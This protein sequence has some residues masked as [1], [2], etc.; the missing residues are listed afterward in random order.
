MLEQQIDLIDIDPGIPPQAAVAGDSVEKAVQDHQHAHGEQLFAQLP[1]IIAGDAGAHV[2][3]GGL[4]KSV[5]TALREQFQSQSH[6]PRLGFRLAQQFGV[7]VLERGGLAPAA[8]PHIV[9]VALCCT[10]VDDRLLLGRQFSGPHRLLTERKQELR[11]QHH[12]VFPLAI[13]LLHVHGVDVVAGGG[14]DLHHLAT[15]SF[16][17]RTVFRLRIDDQDVILGRESQGG[18]LPLGSKGFTGAR[19]AQNKS[20][21]VEVLLAVGNDE[22]FADDILAV[23]DAA[24]VPDLLGFE[25]HE[26]GQG[27]GGQGPQGVDP[28][29]PHGESGDKA[30]ILLP[31]QSS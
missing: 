7:K 8:V 16:Y 6:V 27:L 22:I 30:C 24:P 11:F 23:V 20:V 21:A 19:H 2:H 1:D 4:G 14:R 26:D 15:Q 17:Q 31:V 10:A 28:P 13:A 12:G 5:E 3:I 25:G 29:Q 9:V 18:N